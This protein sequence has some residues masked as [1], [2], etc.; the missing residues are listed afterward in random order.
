MRKKYVSIILALSVLVIASCSHKENNSLTTGDSTKPKNS[1]IG[2]NSSNNEVVTTEPPQSNSSESSSPLDLHLEKIQGDITNIHYADGN[3]IIILA[4]KLY[5]YNLDK[6]LVTAETSREALV[7]EQYFSTHDGYVEIGAKVSKGKNNG[8]LLATDGGP[9]YSAVFYDKQLNK[10]SEFQFNTLLQKNEMIL[11]VKAIA[12][13][14]DGTKAAYA[15]TQ[16]LYLYNFKTKQKTTVV[17]VQ[18]EDSA[19]RKGVVTFEQIGF[20][21]MDKLLAFKAQSFHIPAETDKPSFDTCGTVAIDGSSMSNRVFDSY[22]CKEVTAY[23]NLLL[24]AE[25]FTIPSGKLMVMDIPSEKVNLHTLV[26]KGESGFITGSDSGQYFGTS[27]ADKSSWKIRVYNTVTGRLEAE[28]RIPA[29]GE[30]RYMANDPLIRIIDD[31][32]TYIVV[33]G[34]N[35]P[36]IKAKVIINHF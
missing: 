6:G 21:N 17:N 33:L 11:S 1:P 13:T 29:E 19:P 22:T 30:A 35:Q 31:K 4:D 25:D 16:G 15:T 2:N 32:K 23:S 36:G 9:T 24:F 27:L 12:I 7:K 14:A 8:G 28:K 3:Q 20:T 26:E 34:A 10:K 18:E 5:L